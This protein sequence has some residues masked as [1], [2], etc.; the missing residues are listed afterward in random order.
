MKWHSFLATVELRVLNQSTSNGTFSFQPYKAVSFSLTHYY[1]L[2]H[3]FPETHCPYK[4]SYLITHYYFLL[5]CIF[6]K[7]SLCLLCF[8]LDR[9]FLY[10]ISSP[11]YASVCVSIS[12]LLSH[13]LFVSCCCRAQCS[14]WGFPLES[15]EILSFHMPRW[16]INYSTQHF[17]SHSWHWGCIGVSCLGAVSGRTVCMSPRTCAVQQRG[18]PV[19]AVTLKQECC[20]YVSLL[21]FGVSPTDTH[22]T[23]MSDFT[24]Y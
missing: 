16:F 17:H 3:V 23:L 13:C 19:S 6:P 2:N 11:K 1:C 8:T 15:I 12:A 9:F 10:M 5:P 21:V 22:V 20:I 18:A 14:S 4:C 24:V 7:V